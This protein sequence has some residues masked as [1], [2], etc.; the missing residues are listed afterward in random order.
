EVDRHGVQIREL[1]HTVT[2]SEG[3]RASAAAESGALQRALAEERASRLQTEEAL[4][5]DLTA[6]RA[7]AGRASS[8]AA[9]LRGELDERLAA[10][11]ARDQQIHTLH[12]E[13]RAL[14]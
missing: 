10:I 13:V 11:V 8:D 9:A 7:D 14:R 6:A 4:R 3:A 1:R 2:H 12:A 5:T